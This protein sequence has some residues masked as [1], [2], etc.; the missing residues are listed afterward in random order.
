MTVPSNLNRFSYNGSGNTGPFTIGFP[1]LAETE[2]KVVK[3]V[4]ATGVET[5]LTVNAGSNGYTVNA[6]LTE[7]T[8]TENVAAGEKIVGV[9]DVPLTQQIDFIANDAFP[10]ERNEEGLDRGIMIAQQLQE[11]I[12]RCLKLPLSA[13]SSDISIDDL[14]G[15]AGK[16]A[17]VKATEDGFE[18]LN[19]ADAGSLAVSPF[20]ETV[21]DDADASTAL[22]TLGV[23]TYIKTLLD[24]TTASAAQTTLGGTTV[25]KALFTAADAAAGRTAINAQVAGSYAASG[26]NSDIASLS[27]LSQNFYDDLVINGSMNVWQRNTI[28][29]PS[30][31]TITYT[32]DR[33]AAYRTTTGYTVSRV[34]NAGLSGMPTYG[35]KQQ[36]TAGDTAVNSIRVCTSHTTINT[37]PYAGKQV[38]LSWFAYAGANFSA[39]SGGYTMV[40]RT[41]T[42][43]DQ[44]VINGFTGETNLDGGFFL[45]PGASPVRHSVTFTLPANATGL[46]YGPSFVPVGTAGA[47][48]WM[49]TSGYQID[50]GPVALPYRPKSFNTDLKACEEYYEKGFNYATVPADGAGSFWNGGS[51]GA[52]AYTTNSLRTPAIPFRTK[53]RATP[54][55]GLWRPGTT[56]TNGVLA[57]YNGSWTAM[58]GSTVS[59]NENNFTVYSTATSTSGSS[60]MIDGGW[61]AVSEL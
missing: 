5:P 45:T 29:T 17:R 13:S 56:A 53:K 7:I 55:I 58:T 12:D 10:S 36:R 31:S 50:L 28:F 22:S 57:F 59:A 33:W 39:A 61:D 48:D 1:I 37:I 40:V 34:L 27:A 16:F 52:L 42:G 15:Q 23:S 46:G 38:T 26:A 4:I 3:L 30:G 60:Y 49:Q 6:A 54:T 9:R 21:L 51:I 20:M 24:D 47:N 25:G 41:G 43:T 11:Q 2:L 8:T 19:V 44:N 14:T 35:L 32:A 18:Y